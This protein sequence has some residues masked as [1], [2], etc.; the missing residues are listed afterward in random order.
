MNTKTIF[1]VGLDL[2]DVNGFET[3]SIASD[4]SLL[5]TDIF[6]FRPSLAPFHRYERE[7]YRGRT[8]L[9]HSSSFNV[10]EKID[11]WTAQIKTAFDTGKTIVVFLPAK[12]EVF[13]Y[14]GESQRSE[15]VKSR[16]T[17]NIVAPVSNYDFLPI[18]FDELVSGRGRAMKLASKSE[19]ISAYWQNTASRSVYE[20]HFKIEGRPLIITKS[21]D[22]IVGALIAGTGNLVCLPNLAWSE[23]EFVNEKGEWTEAAEQ[24]TYR[25]RDDLLGIDAALRADTERTSEP[26][27]AKAD[28]FRLAVEAEIEKEILSIGTKI[29]AL[30][31]EREDKRSTL[32]EH[33][34]LRALLFEKGKPLETAVREALK[35]LG[36]SADHFK[37]PGSEFDA[38]FESAEGRFLGEAEG[39]D[40]KPINVDKYSQLE[41]N[42][43]EDF[44]REEVATPAK[45]VLFGNAHR[46]V[47][48][49]Q[50]GEFFTEKVIT[51][52]RRTDSA[53][54]RTPDLFTVARYLKNT[55]D[56]KFATECR[57]AIATTAGG[58]VIFPKC[59]EI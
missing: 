52:A 42:I 19:I 7:S 23:D 32:R 34:S 21:G 2:P 1:S 47:P 33:A 43:N 55:P 51:S 25:L 15:T 39:K 46:R 53:L 35:I 4:R 3:F 11:H 9:S 17:T 8:L 58:V 22:K 57:K 38:L 41:R 24:F 56:E 13:R 16:V 49:G 10:K 40:N 44:A 20:V 14:T 27:W 26:D 36:F 28:E 29:E 18:K 30:G 59:A 54:I 48:P 6:V 45:G 50:R 12:E 31:K 5:D 37:E